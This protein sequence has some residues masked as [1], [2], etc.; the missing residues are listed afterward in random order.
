MRIRSLDRGVEEI[1]RWQ[2]QD[3]VHLP[4]ESGLPPAFLPQF[5][6]LDEVLRRPSLDERLPLLLQPE[7]LDPDLLEP[8][9]LADARL[10]ARTIFR[11]AA[12][13]TAGRRRDVLDRAAQHLE[14][15][16]EL[17][18]EVRRA[19]AVLLRG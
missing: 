10:S 15:A 7:T 6:P 4:R 13:A 2:V 8:S 9:V 18:E 14:A 17:D 12:E 3:E 11:E 16:A 5:R 1:T 19:L